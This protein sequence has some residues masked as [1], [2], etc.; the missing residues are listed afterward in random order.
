MSAD[1]WVRAE[2]LELDPR[3]RMVW[4]WS[5]ADSLAPTTV[6]FELAPEGDGTRLTVTHAG[7]IDPDIGALLVS[8][9]PGRIEL[10]RR[11]LD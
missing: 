2:V 9:W 4:S 5:I 7:Q 1:G 3:R 6:T 10:L 11:S 8:G